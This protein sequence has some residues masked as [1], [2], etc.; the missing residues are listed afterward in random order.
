MELPSESYQSMSSL[1]TAR[2]CSFQSIIANDICMS[3][4]FAKLV[5]KL[6]STDQNDRQVSIPQDR[7][8]CVENE[9]RS[10]KKL[11]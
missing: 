1:V 6:L 3:D 9:E 2:F 5:P 10:L 8:D 4:V 7:F 11:A